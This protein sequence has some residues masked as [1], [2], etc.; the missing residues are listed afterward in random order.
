MGKKAPDYLQKYLV[1]TGRSSPPLSYLEKEVT[2]DL[3]SLIA[4]L[5]G[6]TAVYLSLKRADFLGGRFVVSNWDME[7]LEKL[8]DKIVAEDLL[9]MRI[10]MGGDVLGTVLKED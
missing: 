1:D 8:K 6:G 3:S 10:S 5:P 9:K 7:E 2:A 4:D